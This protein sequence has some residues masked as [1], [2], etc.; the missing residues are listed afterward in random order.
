MNE[1]KEKD[2]DK[3]TSYRDLLQK[4]EQDSQSSYDKTVLT[5]SGG[6]L[7]VSFAFV[8]DI[9]GDSPVKFS[10]ALTI[11]WIMWV[12]SV[13]CVLFSFLF[14]Q[15][16]LKRAVDQI[17]DGKTPDNFFNK[18]TACL[19]IASGILF[20]FGVISIIVFVTNNVR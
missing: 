15:Q 19:N 16:A 8:K 7:G 17:D 13:A 12:F 9:I 5:L 18:V 11:A 20:L 3:P 6:A 10:V 2:N 4:L 14:S 1:E